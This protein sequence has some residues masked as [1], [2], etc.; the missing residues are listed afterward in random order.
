MFCGPPYF[1]R[2][3]QKVSRKAA[4]LLTRS[5]GEH[6]R[7]ALLDF[8]ARSCGNP[9]IFRE[10]QEDFHFQP[11]PQLLILKTTQ[12][13]NSLWKNS[14]RTKMNARKYR[15]TGKTFPSILQSHGGANNYLLRIK[16]ECRHKSSK[17]SNTL[18]LQSDT[19][20]NETENSCRLKVQKIL[21]SRFSWTSS[22][23][24][25]M[26]SIDRS[27]WA[28]VAERGRVSVGCNATLCLPSYRAFFEV[29]ALFSWTF[30]PP[31]SVK[32]RTIW[33]YPRKECG[34]QFTSR[35]ADHDAYQSYSLHQTSMDPE[36]L[37]Y[38]ALLDLKA[39][40]LS[41]PTL[42]KTKSSEDFDHRDVLTLLANH[43]QQIK[44]KT[45]EAKIMAA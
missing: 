16:K 23:T 36:L 41:G 5:R 32:S 20:Q 11:W 39:S 8:G 6:C 17:H 19:P 27:N 45:D 31:P 13:Y 34:T 38:Q 25:F 7:I 26:C 28:T 12:G 1:Q 22:L 18:N 4:V 21:R 10:C 15:M 43:D 35:G 2:H 42:R 14:E 37:L 40:I 30:L 24:D 29:K 9:Y 3:G 33:K 44:T